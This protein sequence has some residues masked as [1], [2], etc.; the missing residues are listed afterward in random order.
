MKKLLS[1]LLV[2]AMLLPVMAVADEKATDLAEAVS[3]ISLPTPDLPLTT[4]PVTLTVM[5]QKASVNQT[6]FENMFQVKAIEQL[7]GIT[8]DIEVIESAVWAEKLPLAIMGEE[9]GKIFLDGISFVDAD[10]FGQSGYLLPLEDLLEEYAPNAMKIFDTIPYARK[11]ATATD[12]HIYLMP[13]YNG[14]PRD[15]LAVIFQE[16]NGQWLKTLELDVPTTLD[17]FYEMLNAF[18]VGDPNGNGINDEIPWSFVWNNGNYNMVLGA[19]G[20]TG[21]RHDVIDGE[22]IYVPSQENYRH[23]VEFMHKLYAEGLLDA[24]VFTQTSEEYTAKMQQMLVGFMPGSHYGTIGL[25]NYLKTVNL[26]PLTSEYNDV[27]MHPGNLPDVPTYGLAITNKA[28]QEEAILAIKLLDFLYS[29]EGTFLTKCGPEYGAWGDEI[30][31]GYVKTV[32]EDGSYSYELVFDTEKYNNSYARFRQMN[33]LWALPFFYSSAHEACIV[34]SDP[35]N[36]HITT[37]AYD[38]GM[39]HA[40]RLGFHNMVTYTEDESS[41][42]AN[43]VLLDEYVDRRV[44][45]WVKGEEELNDATWT[46]YLTNLNAI[47]VN[48][49]SIIRQDAYDRWLNK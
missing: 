16:I 18:K 29:E 34:G 38:S 45:A 27:P 49:F 17:G 48:D 36:N 14:T 33:G 26:C 10:S 8:L 40:R 13:A 44:A 21:G 28:T 39:I 9:Y 15:M 5:F 12:G 22:Y 19:F 41:D 25:E 46:D 4:D 11:N 35:G 43:S 37:K 7:T 30:D 1:L 24:A 31:G 6:D 2:L 3:S 42:L 32:N 47:G 23:Y 20:Y